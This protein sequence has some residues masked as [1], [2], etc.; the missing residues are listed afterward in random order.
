MI[1]GLI[2]LAGS[3]LAIWVYIL[4]W[5]D[6]KRRK[7]VL[8]KI[9]EKRK[10]IDRYISNGRYDLAAHLASDALDRIDFVLRSRKNHSK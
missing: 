7:T 5:R 4:R 10:E 1:E 2:G 9:D 6:Q 3:I 8:E